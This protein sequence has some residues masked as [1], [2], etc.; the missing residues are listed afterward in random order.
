MAGSHGVDGLI[1]RAGD[2]R[3]SKA[4][5][6]AQDDDLALLRRQF[7]KGGFE[8]RGVFALLHA[9]VEES[10]ILAQDIGV[11]IRFPPRSSL[12][13]ATEVEG[14]GADGGVEEGIMFRMRIGPA[15]PEL[16]ESRL[17]DVFSIRRRGHPL[18]RKKEQF[19]R[20]LTVAGFPWFGLVAFIHQ[21]GVFRWG[22]A[23]GH[24]FR[25]E[26]WGSSLPMM[27]HL[28]HKSNDFLA[29]ACAAG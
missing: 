10:G 28:P 16:D 22:N 29:P 17:Q 11:R 25:L 14:T 23:A 5:P 19:W 8:E 9:V 1:E 27:R 18:P 7:A 26:K 12:A 13:A 15:L 21:A 24:G 3:K 6:D 20:E 4:A 2:L